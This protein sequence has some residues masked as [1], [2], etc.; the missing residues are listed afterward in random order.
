MRML[1]LHDAYYASPDNS[2]R[3]SG[4]LLACIADTCHPLDELFALFLFVPLTLKALLQCNQA[5]RFIHGEATIKQ[6]IDEQIL[7]LMHRH[8]SR[9]IW[10][11]LDRAG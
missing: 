7:I 11:A 8:T 2:Q 6:D 5:K 3:V 4:S 1:L 9:C 10:H